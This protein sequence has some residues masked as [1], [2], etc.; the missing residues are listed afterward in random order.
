MITNKGSSAKPTIFYLDARNPT[1]INLTGLARKFNSEK[2]DTA[3]AAFETL[4]EL[5]QRLCAELSSKYQRV[6]NDGR[7]ASMT[8]ENL[9]W[10]ASLILS[11][12]LGL[13]LE[14]KSIKHYGEPHPD[15]EHLLY[16]EV[17]PSV[18]NAFKQGIEQ[19]ITDKGNWAEP[20]KLWQRKLILKKGTWSEIFG[21]L[22]SFP[23]FHRRSQEKGRRN[24]PKD[25][26]SCFPDGGTVAKALYLKAL[27]LYREIQKL[28]HLSRLRI[29]PC[30]WIQFL[31]ESAQNETLFAV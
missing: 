1:G 19:A 15:E 4:R 11:S 12:W 17:I 24:L 22:G 18:L 16:F 14:S 8:F 2:G 10:A 21:V 30:N 13:T 25:S 5:S 9:C 23:W 28:H 20:Q 6:N 29:F 27:G 26:D 31:I 3:S 7:P